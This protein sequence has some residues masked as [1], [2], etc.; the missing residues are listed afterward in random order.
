MP[1]PSP[2][3]GSE[4]PESKRN[5][6]EKLLPHGAPPASQETQEGLPG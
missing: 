5:M 6:R 1:P 3:P 4:S 2:P